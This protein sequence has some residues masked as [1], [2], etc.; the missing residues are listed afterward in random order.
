VPVLIEALK[1][2]RVYVRRLIV[3]SLGQIGPQAKDAVPALRTALQDE[4]SDIRRLAA[5]ALE[6]IERK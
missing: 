3:E 2:Q 4:E 6:K 5:K 1:D